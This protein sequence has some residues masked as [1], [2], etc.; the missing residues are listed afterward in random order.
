MSAI[1]DLITDEMEKQGSI[2]FTLEETELLN[3][4]LKEY[5]AFYKIVGESRLKLFR[6]NKMELVFV[7]LNDD[8]MR[9]GKIN[10][11]GV[12]LPLQVKLTWD[13]DSVDK[14]AVKKADDQIFQE[15]TSLQIDN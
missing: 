12:D 8:W 1:A 10:I 3:P 14:L 15:I 2:E 5:T 11:T 13:N 9:Q 4:D 6:N 7:R